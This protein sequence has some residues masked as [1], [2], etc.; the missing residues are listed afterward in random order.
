MFSLFVAHNAVVT[1][2]YRD[3]EQIEALVLN[4]NPASSGTV[5]AD[6]EQLTLPPDIF[7]LIRLSPSSLNIPLQK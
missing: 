2:L 4:Y 7:T 1:D 3:G 6:E 5:Q